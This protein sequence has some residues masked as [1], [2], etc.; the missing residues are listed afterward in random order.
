MKIEK[1]PK[2]I[3]ISAIVIG[4][5]CINGIAA[6]AISITKQ[7][8]VPFAIASI[9]LGLAG[10]LGVYLCLGKKVV[11]PWLTYLWLLAQVVYVTTM[12]SNAAN[13]VSGVDLNYGFFL[14]PNIA[15][16]FV[17][18]LSD[19]SYRVINLNLITPFLILL[20]WWSIKREKGNDYL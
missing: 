3:I 8:N 20:L 19:V 12:Y 5:A 16:N 9:V 15:F 11:F 1:L 13:Q 18:E 6:G 2:S 17:F 10:G 4:I 7:G 14:F